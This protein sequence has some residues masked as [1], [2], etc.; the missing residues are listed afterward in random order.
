M[1]EA[2]ARTRRAV[3]WLRGFLT[4]AAEL[5]M[6][7]PPPIVRQNLAQHFARW[8][9]ARAELDHQPPEVQARLLFDSRQDLALAGVRARSEPDAVHLAYTSEA[10]DLLLDV[11][12]LGSGLVRLDGQVLP[13]GPQEAPI[14]EASVAGP[15]FTV[16]TRDG[17]E[18]GRFC[19]RD[20]PEARCQLS[21]TNG[22]VVIVADLDLAPGGGQP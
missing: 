10:G 8:S 21:A 1:A 4:T 2:D 16:R 9:R 14:F 3:D 15:G 13:A 22:L 18:L 11:Y 7:E 6:H 20:V 5:P 12:Q 19:L 17:D